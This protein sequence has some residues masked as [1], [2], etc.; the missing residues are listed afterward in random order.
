M[1]LGEMGWDDGFAAAFDALGDG[2]LVPARVGIEH[3]HFY[4]VLTSGG[5]LVAQA[6][7][8]LRHR[9][10]GQDD[11]PAV[12]DWVA[13]TVNR[14][15]GA[16]TI[17]AILPRRSSFA[18]KAAGDPTAKQVVAAN[19]DVVLVVAGLDGDFSPRRIERYL[20]AAADS[21]ARPVVVLNK[22]RPRRE[23]GVVHGDGARG[24]AGRPGP[25]DLLQVRPGARRPRRLSDTGPDGGPAR[26]VRG[27][28]VDHHQPPARRGAAE[29]AGGP[30]RRQ[31]GPDTPRSTAS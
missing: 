3:N 2:G 14:H 19:I 20:V 5:E 9:A 16:G 12:G 4:R 26:L 18:R 31:P 22:G 6:A 10:A 29:D 7:G 23:R 21:G 24:S 25:R 1:T 15:D 11:L 8:R 13:V 30:R 28:Q 17:R 27:R